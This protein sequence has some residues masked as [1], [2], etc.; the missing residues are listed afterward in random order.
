MVN[1]LHHTKWGRK[2]EAYNY[3]KAYDIKE[4]KLQTTLVTY[5]NELN[6]IS[7]SDLTPSEY[8]I[9]QVMMATARERNGEPISMSFDELKKY[10]NIKNTAGSGNLVK[11]LKAFNKKL[12]TK[13]L[14]FDNKEM[15][16]YHLV[17]IFEKISIYEKRQ[18][19]VFDLNY[20]FRRFF[21]EIKES[22]TSYKLEEMTTLKRIYSKEIFRILNSKKGTYRY[23]QNDGWCVWREPIDSFRKFLGIPESYR[24]TDITQ[25]VLEP[26]RKEIMGNNFFADLR[27]EKEKQDK[28]NKITHIVFYFKTHD[29][30]EKERTKAEAE[31]KARK[32][33]EKEQKHK[34]DMDSLLKNI[35]VK[36]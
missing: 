20:Q 10:A 3:K 8:N 36:K 33:A 1:L 28:G 14:E 22:F 19:V 9:L 34:E 11:Q 18:G 32:Q 31:R 5:K 12:V 15:D 16:E 23:Q 17:P 2:M 27:I 6:Q 25:K 7:F 21:N 4:P 24:M 29:Q 13:Y 35:G 26:S 30:A